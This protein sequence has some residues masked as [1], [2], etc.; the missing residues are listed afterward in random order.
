MSNIRSAHMTEEPTERLTKLGN[1]AISAIEGNALASGN[2][3][4]MVLLVDG[5]KVGSATF[6][7]D[8]TR[9]IVTFLRVCL[10]G[11]EHALRN[12]S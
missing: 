1:E 8:N 6:G 5:G 10:E 2:E 7:F 4:G 11:F 9:Q 3:R 12:Q